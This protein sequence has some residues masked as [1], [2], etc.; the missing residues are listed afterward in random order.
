MNSLWVAGKAQ[1]ARAKRKV[2]KKKARARFVVEYDLAYDG[3]GNRWDG[4]YKTYWGART[5]AFWNLHVSSYGGSA[6]IYPYPKA[7]PVPEVEENKAKGAFKWLVA[8]LSH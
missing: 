6:E 7:V 5:A 3:G 1:L 8:K 2:E 4:W